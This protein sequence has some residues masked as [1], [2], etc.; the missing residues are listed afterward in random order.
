MN[1]PQQAAP[2]R[3]Q[4]SQ[5]VATY[6]REL[7]I[8]GQARRGEFLR[9]DTLAKAMRVSS[10]PVRE[11]LLLLQLEGFVKLVPRRGFMVVGFSRQDV[12]D[13]FWAQAVL[14][15]ELAARAS[16]AVTDADKAELSALLAAHEQAIEAHDEPRYTKLGHQFHRAVNLAARSPR[17]A[18]LLG[19]LTKQLPNSFYGQMEGQVKGTLDYH[20]RI[21]DALVAGDAAQARSLM[22]DHIIQGG[23]KLVEYLEHRGI[24]SDEDDQTDA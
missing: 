4:L 19:T 17:L 7:I 23:E 5:D 3:Q 6:V 8:S 16:Q 12:R 2:A 18:V 11:G 20:P 1:L 21:F 14:A 24:W 9:I 13:I 15:G 22:S 10:T